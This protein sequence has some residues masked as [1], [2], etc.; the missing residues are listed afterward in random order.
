MF[1][2][3]KE[4][5]GPETSVGASDLFCS[6][7]SFFF[8]SKSFRWRLLCVVA[9]PLWGCVDYLPRS[10]HS[11]RRRRRS[12]VPGSGLPLR[13]SISRPMPNEAIPLALPEQGSSTLNTIET[14]TGQQHQPKRTKKNSKKNTKKNK[15]T[16]FKH[17]RRRMR[18]HSILLRNTTTKTSYCKNTLNGLLL[19][20]LSSP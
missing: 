7:S 6:C 4:N 3:E 15:T 17:H 5:R 1:K 13:D 20:S 16:N 10:A 19:S 18:F 2:L 9:V 14:P 12:G 8:S 11:L